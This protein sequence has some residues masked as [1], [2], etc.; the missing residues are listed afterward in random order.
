MAKKLG[1]LGPEGTFSH[2]AALEWSDGRYELVQYHSMPRLI[3]AVDAGETD[4]AIVPIENSIEGSVNATLDTLALEADVYITGEH[5]LWIKENLLVKNGAAAEDIKL[6]TSHP[7]PLGQCSKL[8]AEKFPEVRT[9]SAAS[10]SAAAQ[11]TA[12]SDGSVA[13][14]GSEA[15]AALY[16]LDILIPDCADEH[17]NC[18]RFV[19]VEKNMSRHVTGHDKTSIAFTLENKPGALYGALKLFAGASINMV[20]IESRPLKDELGKYIFFIDVEGNIDDANIYFALEKLRGSTE[21]Y[22]FLGSYEAVE[23]R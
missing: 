22:K 7:Q 8:L 10:T 16:G 18:T 15:S 3:E 11:R 14:I 23:R 4:A 5:I 6:I 9:E 21:Y 20:K 19:I 1:Y 13:C 12:E 2:Q 17:S